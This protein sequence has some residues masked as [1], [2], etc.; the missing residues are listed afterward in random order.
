M[1]RHLL[2]TG[3]GRA[4]TTFLV[5]LF[6]VLGMDTGYEDIRGGWNDGCRAGLE[7]TPHGDL[8]DSMPYIVKSPMFCNRIKE[9][10]DRGQCIDGIIAPIRDLR[11]AAG[12][13]VYN[14]K[15]GV[16]AG[17]IVGDS[18]DIEDE[19][20]VLARMTH[21]LIHAAKLCNIPIILPLYPDIVLDAEYAWEELHEFAGSTSKQSFIKAHRRISKKEFVHNYGGEA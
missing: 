5:Q 2:I 11:D 19:M 8:D 20:N 18:V 21:E 6:T 10:S 3:T 14:T 1:K 4:G 12:S 13:R 16:G 17:G 9:L 15:H 7:K